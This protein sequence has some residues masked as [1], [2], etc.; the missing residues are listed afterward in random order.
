MAHGAHFQYVDR[1][2]QRERKID[3]LLSQQNREAFPLLAPNMLKQ[4]FGH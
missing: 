1:V 2:G 3:T 4:I